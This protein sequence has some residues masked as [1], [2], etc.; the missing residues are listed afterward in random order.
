M[1]LATAKKT[2]ANNRA[3]VWKD[4]HFRACFS[5]A[6]GTLAPPCEQICARIWENILRVKMPADLATDCTCQGH[7][8]LRSPKAITR[9]FH[10]GQPQMG[11]LKNNK[12]IMIAVL[13]FLV[14][15]WCV[16]YQELAVIGVLPFTFFLQ[17]HFL[18]SSYDVYLIAV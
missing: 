12:L 15:R 2:V 18:F 7:R 8:Q 11:D 14:L 17:F 6:F 3:E 5:A 4:L 1:W 9:T 13:S 10:L 16:T